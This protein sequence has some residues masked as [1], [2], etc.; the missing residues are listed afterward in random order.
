MAC[1]RTMEFGTIW[2]YR[3]IDFE[4]EETI[5]D[6]KYNTLCS[7]QYEDEEL[8]A[9]VIEEKH[10]NKTTGNKLRTFLFGTHSEDSKSII[11]SD[12]N[13]WLLIF[14]SMGTTD[15]NLAEDPMDG[16]HGYEW[17]PYLIR[18]TRKKLYEL[19]AVEGDHPEQGDPNGPLK[20]YYPHGC[21]WLKYKVLQIT[22]NLGPIT[23]YYKPPTIK[24]APGWSEEWQEEQDER[25]AAEEKLASLK[26]PAKLTEFLGDERDMYAAMDKLFKL[27]EKTTE[28]R[29]RY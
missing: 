12:M 2:N 11:C 22:G 26:D 8:R 19:K 14:G 9:D 4:E 10:L 25:K 1:W 6:K 13:F 16:N 21:S 7:N 18:E 29:D 20:D 5:E 15:P 24:D 17:Q 28:R 23:K 3:L 27:A